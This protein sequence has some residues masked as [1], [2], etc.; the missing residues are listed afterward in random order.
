MKLYSIN[1]FLTKSNYHLVLI[2]FY[3]LFAITFQQRMVPDLYLPVFFYFMILTGFL[4]F[5]QSFAE[6]INKSLF[7][8]ILSFLIL[9]S[10]VSIVRQELFIGSYFSIAVCISCANLVLKLKKNSFSFILL[11]PFLSFISYILYRLMLNP[12]PNYVFQNSRNW[13]SFYGILLLSPYYIL[14]YINNKKLPIFPV[15]TFS[16]L[17][18]YCLGRIGILSSGIFLCGVLY[19]EQKLKYL[20][21]IFPLICLLFGFYLLNHVNA[22]DI[23]RLSNYTQLLRDDR[24]LLWTFYLENLNLYTFLFGMDIFHIYI[25]TG[26]TNLHSSFLNIIYYL[27]VIGYLFIFILSSTGCYLFIIKKYT[28]FLFFTAVVLRISTDVGSLFGFFDIAFW[29]I[30]IYVTNCNKFDK[31]KYEYKFIKRN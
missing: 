28:L 3:C 14:L 27:G 23:Y 29:I 21:I 2:T 24:S 26:Y 19:Y 31:V 15:L 18:F 5:I 12:N 11:I 1:Y 4:I 22:Y 25:S 13:I 8:T 16:L 10:L 30:I 7:I 20:F 17:C 9:I 6:G